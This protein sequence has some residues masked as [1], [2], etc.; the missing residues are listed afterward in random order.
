VPV[1]TRRRAAAATVALVVATG[2]AAAGC[3]G[4]SGGGDA[5]TGDGGDEPTP[6]AVLGSSVAV[7][8]QR[9]TL[10]LKLK[11]PEGVDP[12]IARTATVALR[13][14][15]INYD[16]SKQ[17]ACA[18]ATIRSTGVDGCPKG[19]IVGTGEAFGK[20]DTA[21]T[22]AQITIVNGGRDRVLFSTI[23][24]NPAYVKTVVPGRITTG[25]DGLTIAFTFPGDLQSV[26]G[27][28]VGLR[29]LTIAL[30]RGGAVTAA[31]CDPDW[32]YDAGVTFA[33]RTTARRQ[34]RVT[35]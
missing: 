24:R 14:K 19:S 6:V 33:D 23:I 2:V 12:P 25:D 11:Q 28:P 5:K 15:G 16:G 13:G 27:V 1:Q 34:G 26:G 21:G 8:P 22:K 29:R 7:D 10:A 32:R 4:G 9:I 3:G 20:A 30:N 17:P 18:A 31:R 35:C